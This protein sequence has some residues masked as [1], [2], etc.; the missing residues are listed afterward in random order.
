MTATLCAQTCATERFQERGDARQVARAIRVKRRW[1]VTTQQCEKCGGIHIVL[2]KREISERE[3]RIVQ[4]FA[5]G[6]RWR[7]I[8]D[9]LGL[10]QNQVYYSTNQLMEK[11]GCI[12]LPNLILVCTWLGLIDVTSFMPSPEEIQRA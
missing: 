8:A 5:M 1:N 6:L 4:G 9:E 11:L 12:S 3:I 7:E 10:H 2:K